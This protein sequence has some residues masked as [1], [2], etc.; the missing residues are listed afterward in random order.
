MGKRVARWGGVVVLLALL[1]FFTTMLDVWLAARQEFEGTAEAAVV[2]GAAQYN[3]EPSPA[4]AGRLDLGPELYFDGVVDIVVVTGG[5]QEG[6]FTT[7]A[8]AGYDYLRATGILDQHLLLEVD[9]TSTYES[10]KAASRFLASRGI[11]DIAVVTDPYHARRAQL[12]ASEVGFEAT[13][14]PTDASIG[15]RRLVDETV[16]VCLG[17][18]IGFRRLDALLGS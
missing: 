10:L 7:E 8:K 15:A 11:N 1:Y 3:G 12:V 2:L 9:G 6:D 16:A 4:L 17:R 18:V 13:A 5:N 14:A